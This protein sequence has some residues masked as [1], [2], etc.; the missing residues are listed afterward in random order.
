MRRKNAFKSSVPTAPQNKTI[1]DMVRKN[2]KIKSLGKESYT[3]SDLRDH[4][5][6]FINFFWKTLQNLRI[7]SWIKGRNTS[8]LWCRSDSQPPKMGNLFKIK[9]RS[10]QLCLKYKLEMQHRSKS[11]STNIIHVLLRTSKRLAWECCWQSLCAKYDCQLYWQEKENHASYSHICV[12]NR[13]P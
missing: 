9:V 12:P 5:R 6:N 13:A 8:T 3:L 4:S 1:R 7:D 2:G 11:W 10:I